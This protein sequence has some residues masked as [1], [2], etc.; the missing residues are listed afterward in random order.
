[1]AE[2]EDEFNVEFPFVIYGIQL[3]RV[4]TF[5]MFFLLLHCKSMGKKGKSMIVIS[6]YFNQK[7][8]GDLY[9][10]LNITL[11]NYINSKIH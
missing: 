3:K 8:I 1:M 7:W 4:K 5:P 11:K 10:L 9:T 2:V 6:E